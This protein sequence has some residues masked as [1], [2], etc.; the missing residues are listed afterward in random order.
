MI[1]S[2]SLPI[3]SSPPAPVTVMVGASLQPVGALRL[4]SGRSATSV[5]LS[6]LVAALM[7]VLPIPATASTTFSGSLAQGISAIPTKAEANA[8]YDRTLF[9]HWV[10]AN[11]DCQNTRAEV[12]ISEAESN[13]P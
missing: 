6:L 11:G 1:R 8:G 9:R 2:R 12:L 3:C 13:T 10:D 4:S 5:L 7:L